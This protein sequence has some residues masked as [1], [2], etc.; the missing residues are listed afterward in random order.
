[1]KKINH[2]GQRLKARLS[3]P[4]ELPLDGVSKISMY[5]LKMFYVLTRVRM[6]RRLQIRY[7]FWPLFLKSIFSSVSNFGILQIFRFFTKT[8]YTWN[9][10][11]KYGSRFLDVFWRKISFICKNK[12]TRNNQTPAS[13]KISTGKNIAA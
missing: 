12:S 7:L 11:S 1:M 5:A 13:V 4:Q 8:N 6:K 9:A 3:F 2:R 10:K